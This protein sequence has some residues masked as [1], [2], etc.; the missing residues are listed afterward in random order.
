MN[1]HDRYN[2]IP[3]TKIKI[4]P[5]IIDVTDTNAKNV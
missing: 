3:S 2:N 5:K 1:G 4:T